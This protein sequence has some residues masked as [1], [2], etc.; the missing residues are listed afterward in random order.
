MGSAALLQRLLVALLAL[1]ASAATEASTADVV[2]EA[3][4]LHAQSTVLPTHLLEDPE[5]FITSGRRL[6]ADSRKLQAVGQEGRYV[7][8]KNPTMPGALTRAFEA[9]HDRVLVCTE[10]YQV[11]VVSRSVASQGHSSTAHAYGVTVA[12]AMRTVGFGQSSVYEQAVTG[13]AGRIAEA[14]C[15]L[16]CSLAPVKR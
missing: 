15:G 8:I 1:H 14:S 11:C 13:R 6:M 3:L 5:L 12:A 9:M 16:S 7:L 4:R 2:S 10:E